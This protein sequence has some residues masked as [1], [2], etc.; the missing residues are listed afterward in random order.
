MPFQRLVFISLH[1]F[2]PTL[3]T[4]SIAIAT[5][6]MT[7]AVAEAAATATAEADPGVLRKAR[8]DQGAVPSRVRRKVR[9]RTAVTM[10]LTKVVTKKGL[11]LDQDHVIKH[12]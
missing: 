8:D 3:K 4:G 5:P 9:K 10:I 12:P 7:A 11:D 6:T 1:G 2:F